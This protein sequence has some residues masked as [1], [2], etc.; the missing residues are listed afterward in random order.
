MV[1]GLDTF[2]TWFKDYSDNYIIIGGTACDAA[3]SDAGLTARATKDI[4]IIL[5]I[6]ALSETFVSRFWDF[7]RNAGYQTC[8]QEIEKRNA[9]RFLKP[10]D[11]SFP[12]QIELFSRKPDALALP[13]DIHITPIPVEEGL[14]SLSAI[15]LD[16]NYYEFTL[17]HSIFFEDVHYADATALI[18]LKSYAFLSNKKLKES[19]INIHSINI[20]K[21]KN[22]VFRILP[23]LSPNNT[24]DLPETILYN[25]KE[26]AETI[27]KE[28]PPQQMLNEVGYENLTPE[29]IYH[30]LLSIFQLKQ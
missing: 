19:G 20:D 25:M 15:L 10:T 18:C 23:L 13:S 1:R 29:D 2:R 7:V 3:L 4:D 16:D 22:D 28:L 6:E 26:F 11:T 12:I 14:S 8:E 21:H 9:Y 24:I 30:N 5:I 17:Q 27:E